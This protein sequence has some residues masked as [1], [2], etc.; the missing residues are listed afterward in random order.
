VR[1]GT[2]AESDADVDAAMHIVDLPGMDLVEPNEPAGYRPRRTTM[3]DTTVRAAGYAQV[4]S[5]AIATALV[6]NDRET[7]KLARQAEEESARRMEEQQ[8]RLTMLLR[9]GA[10]QHTITE[11]L[12]GHVVSE[13][14]ADRRAEAQAWREREDPALRDAYGRA[15][16]LTAEYR[17]VVRDKRSAAFMARRMGDPDYPEVV[18]APRPA[19]W[20]DL[21]APRGRG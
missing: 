2:K 3:S 19:G 1:A 7:A 5:P 6:L 8:E 10:T 20:L 15:A 21:V 12:A 16:D 11:F 13:D 9:G 4:W 17:R 14:I 18:S